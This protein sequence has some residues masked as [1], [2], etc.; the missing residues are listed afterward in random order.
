M[1]RLVGPSK[2]KELILTANIID[3]VEAEKIG[4]VNYVVE[5]NEEST[6]AYDRSLELAQAMLPQGPIALRMAKMA[7]NRGMEVTLG[8]FQYVDEF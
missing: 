8:F 2:A 4:L 5:Q 3:G 7:I 1:P 6:K